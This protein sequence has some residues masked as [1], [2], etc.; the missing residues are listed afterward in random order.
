MK[1]LLAIFQFGR[2]YLG[3]YWTRFAAGVLLGVL[4]GL[5]NASFVWATKT[6]FER[7][8]PVPVA[9]SLQP[10]AS[11]KAT[12]PARQ[13]GYLKERLREINLVMQSVVDPWLPK[14]GRTIDN[15]QII[16]GLLFLPILVAIRGYVGYL[17]SYCLGWVS[18]RVIND[19]RLDVLVKLNSLSLDFFNRST[20]GD[21]LTRITGD[22]GMLHKCMTF[23]FSDLIKEPVTLV[24]VFV[25]LCLLDWR[26]TLFTSVFMPCCMVPMIILGR[27]AQRAS[28]EGLKANIS[29]SSL[30]V[31]ALS[32]VRIVKAFALEDQQSDRFRRLSRQLIHH[33]MKGVQAK[34]LVNPLI[35]TISMLGLGVLIV[36]I[37]YT[38]TTT[39]DLVAFLTG[40]LLFFTPIKK[41]ASLHILMQQTRV[42]VDRLIK[43]MA[44][45]PTVKEAPHP[46]PIQHFRHQIAFEGL[47]F[48]YSQPSPGQEAKWVLK[49]IN[50]TVPRGM[51]LGI[52]GESGSGKST[53]VN[54]L[55]R[56][57]D[58]TRG[59]VKIDGLDIRELALGDV[60][61]LM[62]LV[63]QEVIVF[64]QSVA[65][66]IACGKKGATREEVEAA[67]QAAYAH[68]FILRLDQGYD[69]R[70]GERGVTLSGGQR[71]RIAIARAFIRNAPILVLD[72][73]TASLDS[74]SE[75]EVQAAIDHLAENRT[76]ICVAHRLSTL[77]TMDQVIV[78]SQGEIVEQGSFQALVRAGGPFA[79]MAARQGIM[80]LDH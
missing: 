29:Q 40:V 17:S 59:A 60:R 5:T 62:A 39:S 18:E 2:I 33:G 20:M 1:D 52:A 67:A 72:E 55:L 57:Y 45:Q 48:A 38:Q 68:D 80:I 42:G 10:E 75:A 50:L 78:L 49:D 66:N 53:L 24:S 32:S 76:V 74:Q 64:D 21:L 54:L 8:E 30:L 12:P 27:K 6:L 25:G 14:I 4:F 23:G 73:A 31:E 36:Y 3:R 58:P 9:K 13:A 28:R 46:K 71:Q 56:F 79:A 37:F 22:T 41:L 43:I 47:S 15:R 26:L 70:L 19:L 35:E 16:G 61:Q 7:L 44:E 51:K 77:A 63:S 34:E 65:E 69:T 11:R